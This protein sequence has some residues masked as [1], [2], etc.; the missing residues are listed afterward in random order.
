MFNRFASFAA[1]ACIL[2]ISAGCAD[3]FDPTKWFE[4]SGNPAAEGSEAIEPTSTYAV[5]LGGV[6]KGRDELVIYDGNDV[7]RD[8]AGTALTFTTDNDNIELTPRD[9][10]ADYMSG[11]G[12]KIIPKKVG[13]TIVTYSVDGVAS[14][15]QYKVIVP[16][17]SL[18]QI[19]VGEARGELVKEAQ[20]D[21]S[22]VLLDSSS[23]TANAIGAVIR[24]RVLLTEAYG[25]FDLFAADETVWNID[26]PAS[27]WDAVITARSNGGYQFTPVDPYSLSHDV[28]MAS[29]KRANLLDS[30]ELLA[31]DQAVISAAGLFSNE[32]SDPTGVSFAF[33]TP[34]RNQS[35]CLASALQNKV[36]EI[37]YSCGSGDENYPAFAPV[38]ILLHPSVSLLDDGRPSF[39]FYRNRSDAEVAVTNAP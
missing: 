21:G 15:D 35:D 13:T 30:S 11:S 38:Q 2:G 31:Y 37:P 9:G 20:V 12:A 17:Q 39:V 16:P 36:M 34:T 32:I 5:A 26:P 24:N 1:L 28:Y 7:V 18:V 29:E 27:N 8:F 22:T 6:A 23:P 10:F 14:H 19:L 25:D 4:N 33:F 3:M